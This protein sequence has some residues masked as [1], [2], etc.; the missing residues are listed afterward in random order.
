ELDDALAR[1][2]TVEAKL[3]ASEDRFRSILRNAPDVI[4][5][6]D[7][8]RGSCVLLNRP[9]LLGHQ[10]EELREP[11]GLFDRVAADD[12][13]AAADFWVRLGTLAPEQIAE[14]T[15]RFVNADGHDHHL[16]LRCSRLPRAGR[17]PVVL[18]LISDV[19]DA[20]QQAT[21]EGEL[22]EALH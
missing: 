8:D 2:R 9:E 22:Q 4:A 3:R 11:N 12:R 21:R 5:T 18:G 13:T 15:L 14:T 16:R 20:T 10:R 17:E 19:T 6:I 1:A 7:A